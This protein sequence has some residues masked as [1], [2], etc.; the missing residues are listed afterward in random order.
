[1]AIVLDLK[2]PSHKVLLEHDVDVPMRDGAKLKANV[3]HPETPGKYPVLMTLGPYGKDLHFKDNSPAPWENLTQNHPEIFQASSGKYMVFER[4][5]PEVWVPNGY[6]IVML[7]SRG[8]CKSPGKLDVNAPAEYRDFYDAIEWAAAQPWSNG[9]IGLLGIS[10]YCCSQWN[11]AA[12]KPPHLKAILPWQ[13]TYDFYRGRTRQGGIFCNGFVARWW[14]RIVDKQHGNAACALKDMFTG[15]RITAPADLSEAERQANREEY[16]ENVL[17]HPQLDAWYAARSPDLSKIDIPAFVVAN[18]GG[19]GLHLRGTIEGWR[20]I[21][22]KDKWLK[23]Q[24]GS[25]FVSFFLP[26]NVALQ[27]KFFD[28]YLK[29]IDNGWEKEPRVEVQVRSTEDTVKR[30]VRDSHWPLSVTKWTRLYLDASNKTLGASAPKSE[31]FAR[32]KATSEGVAFTTAP[33]EREMEFA[34]PMKAR[35]YVSS[36]LE[37]MDM[38]AAVCAFDPQG[39]EATFFASDEPKFPVSMG[40]LRV[41]HR[42]LDRSRTTD[43]LPWHTHDERQPL[44]PGEVYEIEVEI[45][46]GSVSLPAGSRISLILA[47][48]DFERAGASGPFKGSG[49]F[50][51]TDP[52]DRPPERY[53]GEHTIYTGPGRESYLQLPVLSS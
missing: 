13:G 18:Y 42:K 15:E 28:R 27:R 34:G 3:F 6:A 38:F 35:L 24:R 22:S 14:G 10:Y 37:D 50:I 23:V 8:A 5:D 4:P 48:R 9:N 1:M 46:P 36:S 51:H 33:L 53:S 43:W 16:I 30:V 47:G 40:W 31:S 39:K 26:E 49:P 19:L 32:Y 11:V 12:L 7:D 21:A 41:V 25:Y 44:K 45:W 2:N 17:A 29:G 52:I 20:G